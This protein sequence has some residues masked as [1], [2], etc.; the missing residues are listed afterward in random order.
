M[1]ITPNDVYSRNLA[2]LA[3]F[4]LEA[5]ARVDAVVVPEHVVPAIGRDGSGTFRLE[6]DN[7]RM[8]WLG[9]SSMP[10]VSAPALFAGFRSDGSNVLLPSVLSG[11]EPRVLANLLPP[12]AAVFVLEEDPLSIK[13]ALHL[14]NYTN[15]LEAGRVVFLTATGIRDALRQ[16]FQTHPGYEL[17]RQLIAVP[18]CSPA[19]LSRLR[20]QLESAGETV[21]AVQAEV[22]SS[23]ARALR[24]RRFDR[25]PDRPRVAV[26]SVDAMPWAIEQAHRVGHALERLRFPHV[27]CVP[28]L[29]EHSHQVARLKAID[30]VSADGALLINCGAQRLRAHLPLA[31]PIAAWFLTEGVVPETFSGQRSESDLIYA[32]SRTVANALTSAGVSRDAVE[33]CGV[34]TDPA[35]F[36]RIRLTPEEHA[37]FGASVA[38]LMDLPDDR[39]ASVGMTLPSHL[40][41][42]EALQN[43]AGNNLD[44]YE[45]QPPGHWLELAQRQCGT[46][47]Q[48]ELLREQFATLL[49]IQIAPAQCGRA[50]VNALLADGS[51]VAA[52]GVNWSHH[53]A[54]GDWWRGPIPEMQARNQLLNATRIVVLCQDGLTEVQAA[55]DALAVATPVVWRTSGEAF[56]DEYPDLTE[57]QPYLH[58]FKTRRELVGLVRK[59][60]ASRDSGLAE[61]AEAARELVYRNH[62]VEYRVRTILNDMRK[63][64]RQAKAPS[65]SE[66][67]VCGTF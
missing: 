21:I 3:G 55:V 63:G 6:D 14:Y 41:L 16:F 1:V 51:D 39:P 31:F 15:L 53:V 33:F 38:V 29:P 56:V 7:G 9:R 59:L 28:E 23:C 10:S 60:L 66:R 46:T 36:R 34:A 52:W 37:A 43:V 40:R 49:D 57:L 27:V 44:E 65:G 5:A 67:D 48:G 61:R 30:G 26:L 11:L 54:G 45:E 64:G 58:F 24:Q 22:V 35:L 8:H 17:P 18:Q 32:A 12:F 25:L 20:H 62:T 2:A 4:Q 19:E 47:L 13:L 50:T 42:W